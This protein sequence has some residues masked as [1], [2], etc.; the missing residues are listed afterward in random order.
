M[1][2][3]LF[4]H[5]LAERQPTGVGWY[6]RDLVAGLTTVL[7]GGDSLLVASTREAE[8][9]DWIPEPANA[10]VVP[11]PRRTVQLAWCL[12]LGPRVERSLGAVDV[13]HL[14]QPFPPVRSGS[15]Q[16][17]TIHDLWPFEHPDWYPR[18]QRWTYRRSTALVLER[19]ARIVVPSAYVAERVLDRLELEPERVKVVPHG[20]N[21]TFTKPAAPGEMEAACRRFGLEPSAYIL[22]VGVVSTRKNILVL[23]RAMAQIRETGIPLVIVGPDGAGADLVSAEIERQEM[24]TA[25]VI[26]TGYLTHEEVALLIRGAAVLAHPALAE[27]FGFVPLEAMAA[28]TAVVASGS[29]AIPE[30]V[31][32]AGILVANPTEPEAWAQALSAVLGQAERRAALAA[33][34]AK[35]AATF[36]WERTAREMLSVYE[37]A[38]RT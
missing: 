10:R 22:S 23:V 4:G 17:A 3:A 34:G 14:V 37:D 30:V 29:G 13:T 2:I 35:R 11:W 21:R 24:G 1:R 8:R 9:P 38:A 19:A 18:S 28:G 33:A 26:R 36:S 5:R 25:R 16:V 15:P 7:D 12:G 31:G 32:E 20:L 27:G 6:L